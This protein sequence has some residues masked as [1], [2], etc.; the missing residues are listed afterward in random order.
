M[1]GYLALQR[2]AKQNM[3][4]N[5]GEAQNSLIRYLKTERAFFTTQIFL[6]NTITKIIQQCNN[7]IIDQNDKFYV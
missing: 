5:L 2:R 1:N 6:P 7:L 4:K 3:Q